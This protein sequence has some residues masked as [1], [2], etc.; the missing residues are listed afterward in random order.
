MEV[1]K[2]LFISLILL[3]VALGGYSAYSLFLANTERKE[4]VYEDSSANTTQDTTGANLPYEVEPDT[5]KVN[6]PVQVDTVAKQAEQDSL[7]KAFE[8]QTG[9][10]PV[11][12]PII[13][14]V[15]ST[16][17]S[18]EPV[19]SSNGKRYKLAKGASFFYDEPNAEAIKHRVWILWTNKTKITVLDEQNGFMQVMHTN[20]DG[21]VTKGWLNKNDLREVQ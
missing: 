11:V 6:P 3:L 12:K 1:S 15:E 9:S 14:P 4:I 7:K 16:E 20:N 13:P 18:V 5:T 10:T 17:S 8:Q 19:L 2:P 21:E